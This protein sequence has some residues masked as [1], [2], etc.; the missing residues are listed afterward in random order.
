MAVAVVDEL[1]VVDVDDGQ[2][3]APSRSPARAACSSSR[4][5]SARW[6]RLN[7]PVSG[8]MRDCCSASG[9]PLEVRVGAVELEHRR[10]HARHQGGQRGRGERDGEDA[11]LDGLREHAGSPPSGRR[12][13][14]ARSRPA[15]AARGPRRLGGHGLP[16]ADRERPEREHPADVDQA[17]DVVGAGGD[18]VGVGAVGSVNRARPTT[19]GSEARPT[20][21][22]LTAIA[23]PVTASSRRSA[24]GYARL[25]TSVEVA[26]PS[27]ARRPRRRRRRRRWPRSRRRRWPR[28]GRGC[29]G[30]SRCAPGPAARRR[31]RGAGSR[32]ARAR[33]PR[34]GRARVAERGELDDPVE[35]AGRPRGHREGDQR[36][37]QP[38]AAHDA[39]ALGGDHR[40]QQQDAAPPPVADARSSRPGS[41]A[42]VAAKTSCSRTSTQPTASSSGLR[43]TSSPRTRAPSGIGRSP[44]KVEWAAPI[45]ACEPCDRCRARPVRG[46]VRPWRASR[47]SVTHSG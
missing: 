39:G 1:E 14:R 28:R 3:T 43:G 36:P 19:S 11:D 32:R 18:R 45:R 25:V 46:Y 6:R 22:P 29:A 4:T 23:A 21:Q 24:T 7:R 9:A 30:R 8:S 5:R 12:T 16:R 40:E 31:R 38:L 17:A 37:G 20:R 15:G 27:P 2:A 41:A 13:P 35:L 47:T 26:A 42:P 33:P 44:A 34:T 10:R